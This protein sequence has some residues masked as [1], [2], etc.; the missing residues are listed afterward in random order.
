MLVVGVIHGVVFIVVSM[1]L[2]S[3]VQAALP[4]LA[5]TALLASLHFFRRPQVARGLDP[6]A[7]SPY[8]ANSLGCNAEMRREG[9][10]VLIERG[11]TSL[12]GPEFVDFRRLFNSE[13][14]PL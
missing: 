12:G 9:A 14:L 11:A 13:L 3:A 4:A 7:S 6:G 10:A 2:R 5:I 8:V 1:Q